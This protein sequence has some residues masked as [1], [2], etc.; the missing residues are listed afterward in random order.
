ML[1]VDE[2]DCIFSGLVD[3]PQKTLCGTPCARPSGVQSDSV[4]TESS[5]QSTG[6]AGLLTSLLVSLWAPGQT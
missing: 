3:Q 2:Q 6:M 5:L 1:L 4:L